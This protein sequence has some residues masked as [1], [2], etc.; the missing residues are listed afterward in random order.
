MDDLVQFLHA[1]LHE[2][3]QT[4]NG[5]QQWSASWHQD[6]MANEIR[7]DEN[8]GTVAFVPRAGDRAHIARHDP[9]RVLAEIG[10]KRQI[11]RRLAG[12]EFAL[13]VTKKDTVPHGLMTG[14]VNSWRDAVRL[15]AVPYADHPDYRGEWRPAA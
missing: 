8:A 13:S 3:E 11:L 5:H 15:L 9:A 12:A 4:A 2:D 7:D 14:A 1:R 10:A 6:D